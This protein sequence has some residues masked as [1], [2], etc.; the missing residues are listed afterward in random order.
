MRLEEGSKVA[1]GTSCLNAGKVLRS[2]L[3][4]LLVQTNGKGQGDGNAEDSCHTTKPRHAVFVD[5]QEHSGDQNDR[6]H[7]IQQPVCCGTP[8][9]V[10]R[11]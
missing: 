5:H 1:L 7:F 3:A 2:A 10:L 11:S 9:G 8:R 6:G 4:N